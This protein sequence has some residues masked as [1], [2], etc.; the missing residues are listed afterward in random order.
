MSRARPLVING[1]TTW[2]DT[3]Q[4]HRKATV[5]QLELLAAVEDKSIDDI[6][7][8]G[9]SQGQVIVRLRETLHADFIPAEVLE[10]RRQR[11][12]DAARQPECRICGVT[13]NST[14]HHFVPRWLMLEL[15]NYQS[16]AARSKCCIPLCV[17]CHRDLHFRDG[18][19]EK[20]IIPF[21]NDAERAFA[22]KILDEL[23][24]QHPKI[25]DLLS[26]GDETTYE[27]QLMRDYYSGA[28]H[29]RAG[30]TGTSYQ[31]G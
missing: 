20:S 30:S 17:G 23:R 21:L 27:G 11:K 10:R 24:E 26:A 4:N 16:Y 31:H 12:L 8:E 19:G 18:T 1:E 6:L 14:R 28:F 7:D 25:F 13:G 29:K 3:K 22:A 15:E 5:E 2:F 9:L